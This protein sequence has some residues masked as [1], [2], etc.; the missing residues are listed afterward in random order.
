MLDTLFALPTYNSTPYLISY[1]FIGV[2]WI[3][4]SLHPELLLP[5]TF[6]YIY[7]HLYPTKKNVYSVVTVV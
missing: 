1:I 7:T 6:F 4:L 3:D 2:T 5:H